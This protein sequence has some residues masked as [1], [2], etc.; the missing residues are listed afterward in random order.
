MVDRSRFIVIQGGRSPSPA[1]R[2]AYLV[3]AG[4]L[5][6]REEQTPFQP[7]SNHR[8]PRFGV[9][10]FDTLKEA[11]AYAD[12]YKRFRAQTRELR[13]RLHG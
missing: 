13:E 1:P 6:I 3:C 10:R 5:S 8:P 12:R 11:E 2:R 4:C 9:T 7:C